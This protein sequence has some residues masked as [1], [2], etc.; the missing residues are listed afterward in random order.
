MVIIFSFG[1]KILGVRTGI[2]FNNGMY[3]FYTP[4]MT[5]V[6]F[7]YIEAGKRPRSYVAP[8][9]LKDSD[10]VVQMTAGGS[11]SMRIFTGSSQVGDYIRTCL[12]VSVCKRC[13]HSVICL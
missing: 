10:G 6:P 8:Q 1:C 9:M 11:G 5:D 13:I 2:V 3:N 12:N 4:L 7:N